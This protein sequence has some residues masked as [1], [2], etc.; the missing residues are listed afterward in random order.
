MKFIIVGEGRYLNEFKSLIKDEKVI[1]KFV[2]IPRQPAEQIP[3]LLCA[4]DV[5]FLS[6][7]DT[8]LFE[9]TIP[10][11][12]QSYIAC[13]MPILAA[14]SG[15]T[16]RIIDEAQ[17]GV[18]SKIGDPDDLAT[19]ICCMMYADLDKMSCNARAYFEKHFDKNGLIDYMDIF[20]TDKL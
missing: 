5:A 19:A 8:K 18:C 4:C 9:M 17:C 14:A 7:M 11:K 6:F 20:F 3:D 12:L 16:K 13:G 10:A 2:M 15:E 1:D